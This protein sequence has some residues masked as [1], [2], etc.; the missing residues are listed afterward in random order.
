MKEKFKLEHV[1]DA[2]RASGGIITGA[3]NKLEQAYGSCAPG[4]VRNYL[5]RY[6]SLR[7]AVEDMVE[8]NLDLAEGT[9]LK[10]MAEGNLTA[11]IFYLKTKGKQ[12]GY[13][14][15]VEASGKDGG[16]LEIKFVISEDDANL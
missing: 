13:I 6:A 3:A 5:K 4:S 10:A 16:P 11:A 14:E 2:L 8:G 7:H 9:I 15:R 1:E 12:R